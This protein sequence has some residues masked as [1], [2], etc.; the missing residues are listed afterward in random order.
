MKHLG[1]GV[2]SVSYREAPSSVRSAL[3]KADSGKR[4]PS[5]EL[6]ESG[7]ARGIVRVETCS[8][9]EWFVE[10]DEPQWALEL[11]RSSLSVRSSE[12]HR[13]SA[14]VGEPAVHHLLRVAAGLD[15]IAQG[16]HAVGRQVLKAF[17]RAHAANSTGKALNACWRVTG[18]L[19]HE[20]RDVLP[21]R[22]SIGVQALAVRALLGHG[23]ESKARVLV[24]GQGDIGRATSRALERSG[25]SGD[26]VFRR[27]DLERFLKEAETADAVVV[28]SGAP[29]AWLEL[30]AR[31]DAPVVVD[32]GS[33]AQ[34][35]SAKGWKVF[36]LDHL[37]DE[38][39]TLL[40]DALSS[41]VASACGKSAQELMRLLGAPSERGQALA[42]ID[43]ARRS[44]LYETLPPLL[45][46]LS[47]SQARAVVASVSEFTH[48]LIRE[49]SGPTT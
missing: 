7:K 24:F 41:A 4:S 12:A 48:Q 38:G 25:F 10:A 47:P 21:Q 39:A 33:P 1:L 45:E 3:L 28:C 22:Q 46:G 23:L 43:K 8:R 19:L 5:A 29:D 15:S 14:R 13:L 9:V 30:P 40:P 49:V 27:A 36:S 34:L 16:E 20:L 35:I 26:N 32:V 31:S 44:F 42:A 17:E 11:L 6:L 37:L 18:N 2:V